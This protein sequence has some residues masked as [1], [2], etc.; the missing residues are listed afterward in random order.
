METRY[1]IHPDQAKTLDTAGLR[2][3]FL[4]QQ[5]FQAGTLKLLYSHVDRML[6]GAAVPTTDVLELAADPK[7]LGA[8][9]FL[10]RR[11]LGV[12]NL[13][14]PGEVRVDGERFEMARLDGLYVGKGHKTVEFGSVQSSSPAKFYFASGMAHQEL[15]TVL[16]TDQKAKLVVLGSA[17][18]A[19]RRT[20]HQVIHPDVVK[21][22]SLVMGFTC[23]EPGSVWNTMPCHTHERRMEVYLYFDLPSDAVVL[24]LFGHPAETRHLVMRNEE[25][26]ISPSWSIH[27]GVGSR[28]YSFVWAMVGEN[29][30]FT[31]MD[32][33]AM[34][35]LR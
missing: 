4:I 28:N 3:E 1:A 30:T 34:D 18:E 15:P 29:Q 35:V 17:E 33:V 9:Y 7:T 23:L 13:G 19:N 8:D 27:T 14:G 20:I 6:V 26:V 16:V 5:L 22:C 21:T 2:R 11:E 31:D 24:H 10:E 25:A 32:A 12:L